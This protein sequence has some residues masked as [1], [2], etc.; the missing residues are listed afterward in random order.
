MR[1]RLTDD[2]I[3]VAAKAMRDSLD[4]SDTD[5]APPSS[6]PI[7]RATPLPQPKPAR[8]PGCGTLNDAAT[9]VDARDSHRPLHAGAL[10]ICT[11]CLHLSIFTDDLSLRELTDQELFEALADH[12][13]RRTLKLM[14][15]RLRR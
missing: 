9:S 5:H 7:R 4:K 11:Q 1:T 3:R 12:D 13:L 8:C 15:R 2:E 14:A 6:A 10:S